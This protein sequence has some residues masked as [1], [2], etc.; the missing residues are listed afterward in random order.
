M[1]VMFHVREVL[2]EK[3]GGLN[4]LLCFTWNTSFE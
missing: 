2:S 4:V 3:S 1:I